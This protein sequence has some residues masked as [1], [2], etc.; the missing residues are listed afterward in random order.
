MSR[1]LLI[2]LSVLML[3]ACSK[4]LVSVPMPPPPANLAS[5]CPQIA[6]MPPID[7]DR[8]VWEGDVLFSYAE[9]AGKHLATVRAWNEAVEKRK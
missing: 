8:A 6:P 2:A 3:P 1:S 9:C 4:T 5:P 7:P